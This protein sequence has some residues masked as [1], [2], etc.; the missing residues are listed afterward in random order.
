MSLSPLPGGGQHGGCLQL[1]EPEG[2]EGGGEVRRDDDG[3]DR[4]GHSAGDS[5]DTGE[6]SAG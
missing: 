5:G 1:Q 2:P 6:E 4:D 3:W